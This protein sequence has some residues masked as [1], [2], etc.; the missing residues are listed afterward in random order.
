MKKFSICCLALSII[1]LISCQKEVSF[2]VGN[3]PSAGTLQSETTGDC[4][5]KSVNG[6]YVKAVPLVAATN[7]I[8]V[9][10]NVTETGTY[11]IATDTVNGYFFRATGTFTKLG[12]NT[13]TLQSKGTPFIE[14]INNFVVSY[15][16]KSCDIAVTVLATAP[17][18]AVYTL[19]ITAGNCTGAVINGSY[20]KTIPL[21]FTNT[22]IIK[23]NVTA[24]GSYTITATA[25]GMTF[26]ASSTFTVTGVQNVTLLGSG[27]PVNNENTTVPLTVNA[28]TCNFVIPVGLA[29]EG[30]LG[31]TAG[32]CTPA[33][34][35]G[36]YTVG[37]ALVS[38]TNTVQIQVNITTAGVFNI[39]TNAA[40]GIS[41]SASGSF[42]VTGTTL[43]TLNGTGTPSSSGIKT[44]TVT[45]G[46]STCTFNVTVTGAPGAG[47]CAPICSSADIQGLYE[48]TT[49]L[50]VSNV[51]DIDVNVTTAGTYSFTIPAVNGMTFT[52]SGTFATTGPA[53]IRLI[54]SG[55]PVAPGNSTITVPGTPSCTF[56]LTVDPIPIVD[57]K[58]TVTNPAPSITYQGQT[59]VAQLQSS[60]GFLVFAL[61]GSNSDGTDEFLIGFSD[62]NTI[63]AGETYSTS[64]V[65]AFSYAPVTVNGIPNTDPY[66]ASPTTSGVSITFTVT[67]HNTTTKTITG[68]F[69]GTAKNTAGQIITITNGTFR[70]INYQ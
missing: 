27:T 8:A 53:T 23:V 61:G 62:A 29:A 19:E 58:F 69:T 15:G 17:N 42:P 36:T 49:Q 64:T 11:V 48:A 25:N 24:V 22:V 50:N 65:A 37:T 45:F 6:V 2:E 28:T 47:V 38:T 70:A 16:G 51:I 31:T 3:K 67:T 34:V 54:G 9:S 44:F 66:V 32:A 13:V 26:S 21:N 12:I 41:F 33:T 55:T 43:V 18:P 30:T 63:N 59:D 52:S 10:V 20:A 5:P 7:T 39:V 68:T 46:T 14:G 56:Q 4:L 57:W 1:L 60:G 40:S 35:N